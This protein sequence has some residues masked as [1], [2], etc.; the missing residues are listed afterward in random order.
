[1][2]KQKEDRIHDLK[3]PAIERMLR[4]HAE[5]KQDRLPNCSKLARE[6]EVSAKTISR[7]N[8]MRLI[9]AITIREKS[10]A[11]QPST[12]QKANYLHSP[13]PASRFIITKEPRSKNP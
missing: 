9:T 10:K 1:M 5:L 2:G 13:S 6:L 7:S 12:Y 11:Y 3:R 4:I 8:T